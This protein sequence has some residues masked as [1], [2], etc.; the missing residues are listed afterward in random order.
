MGSQALEVDGELQ[1]SGVVALADLA[2]RHHLSSELVASNMSA[3][4]GA[5]IRGR[6]EGGL[7][8]TQVREAP[9]SPQFP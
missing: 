8:Y 2:R 3:R 1:E 4:L 7:L 6:M 9:H 5:I